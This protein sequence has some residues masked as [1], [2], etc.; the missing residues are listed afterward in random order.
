MEYWYRTFENGRYHINVA[1][2]AGH[3]MLKH[4]K[5]IYKH[6]M[7]PFV[8][9]VHSSIEGQPV[10]DGLVG[11]LTPMMRYI[12]RYAKYL[13]TNLRLSSK[14]RILYRRDSNINITKLMD[15]QQDGIEGDSVIEGQDWQY[16]KNPP[17]N[18]MIVNQMLNMQADLKQD[19]GANQ[20]TRGETVGNVTSGKAFMALQQAGGKISRMNTGILNDGFKQI[21]WQIL[22]LMAQFY[23][24]ARM[25]KI[26]GDQEPVDYFG[27][28]MSAPKYTVQVEVHQKDPLRIEAQNQMF[29]DMY[30]MAAQAQQ[31]FPLSALISVMNFD[32]KDKV[33]PVVLKMEA[34]NDRI[35]ALSQ[36]N[37]ELIDTVTQMQKEN[38][39]LKQMQSQSTA[40]LASMGRSPV[41]NQGRMA[42]VK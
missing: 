14:A 8:T 30:T 3:S 10:G 35:K 36:Q 38:D 34:E 42:V 19:S 5:D 16:L 28:D 22:C 33:M 17:L 12:N 32:G 23:D 26:T 29:V 37:T 9:D 25:K 11:E 15:W 20:F 27:N 4:V 2:I 39:A 24:N 41:V 7:Y 6:G 40:A 1:H 21:V 13:D 31:Y 18:N